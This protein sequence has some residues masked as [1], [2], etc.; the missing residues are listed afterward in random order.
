MS[1]I[2]EAASQEVEADRGAIERWLV[3]VAGRYAKSAVRNATRGRSALRNPA[4]YTA[5]PFD[6]HYHLLMVHPRFH[7][8]GSDAD[9]HE[10]G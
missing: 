3:V 6:R 4:P 9:D 10:R 5:F 7:L 8:T 2:L 1:L